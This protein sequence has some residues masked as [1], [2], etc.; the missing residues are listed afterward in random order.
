ML[1]VQSWCDFYTYRANYMHFSKKVNICRDSLVYVLDCDLMVGFGWN[2][3]SVKLYLYKSYVVKNNPQ[4]NFWKS[5][6][7]VLPSCLSQMTSSFIIRVCW[8]ND[9][10]S[11]SCTLKCLF[12]KN[13]ISFSIDTFIISNLVKNKFIF[14]VDNKINPKSI[15]CIKEIMSFLCSLFTLQM[16]LEYSVEI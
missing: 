11:M 9:Q 13:L 1:L 10:G 15:H 7:T 16:I 6:A 8:L 4:V 14:S 2:S 12:C 5:I 3:C